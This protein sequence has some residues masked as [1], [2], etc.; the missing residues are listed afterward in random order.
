MSRGVVIYGVN[1]AKIDY[2]QLA[3]MAA[4]FVRKNMPFTRL[5]L[6]TDEGSK[7]YYDNRGGWR[8]ADYFDSWTVL[9]NQEQKFVNTR[10]YRDTRYYQFTD[11][12]KN[13]TRSLVYDLSPFDETILIDC[14]FL[15][16]N[17]L[18]SACWGSVE[19][20]MINQRATNLFHEEF[21]GPEYRLSPFGIK[22]YWATCIYFRKSEKAKQLF[23]L[24]EHIKDNWD[25]YK[26][27]Y[28]VPGSLF[29]NDYAFSIAIHCLNDFREDGGF[30]PPL[31]DNSLLTA[32]DT[33]QLYKIHSPSEFSFFVNDR[34]ET[35]KFY[36]SRIKGLNVHCMNKL[37]LLNN[38][39]T[40][41]ETLK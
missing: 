22:M 21:T 33:D 30:A 40:I 14:D 35:W 3:V 11:T 38:L 29:R 41:M 25:F 36:V 23:Q 26:L 5:H 31:P 28:D 16:G 6:I 1:N 20:V 8:I 18:L 27:T 10:T 7:S 2:I 4:A 9:P 15:V 37:S 12:F 32:L 24:V 19:D 34:K 13:E 39:D 17:N